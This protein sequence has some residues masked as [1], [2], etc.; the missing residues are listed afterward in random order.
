MTNTTLDAPSLASFIEDSAEAASG[1]YLRERFGAS[2]VKRAVARGDL[3]R[4][5]PDV[6]APCVHAHSF[7]VRAKAATLWS[8]GAVSGAAALFLWGLIEEPPE[9]IEVLVPHGR[10]PKPQ[11]G[12][13]VRQSSVDLPQTLR[14]GVPVVSPATAV[15]LSYG[16]LPKSQRASVF[17]AAVRRKI[18][19]APQLEAVLATLPR[20]KGRKSLERS[21]R[22]AAAG[23]QSW[24]EERAIRKVFNTAEFAGFLPQHEV[25]IE[26]NQY[27]LD[28]FDPVTKTCLELDGRKGH[29]NEFRQKNITRDCW[30][31]T[32]G[33][34]TLRFSYEDLTQRPEWCRQV[35]REVL[36]A[37]SAQ[38]RT[39]ART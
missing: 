21:A 35:V 19:G 27:F 1:H 38:S 7:A 20:V 31:A 14:N 26:G 39:S 17:Y 37:R 30:V 33:I 6:Y 25:V 5:L 9:V 23:A 15:V 24:L 18:V 3:I 22:A 16:L 4:V 10:N 34:L 28:L 2:A 29:V 11:P 32:R 12:F 13:A 8:G 36:R